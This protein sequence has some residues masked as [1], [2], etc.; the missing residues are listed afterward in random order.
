M[1]DLGEGTGPNLSHVGSSVG[2]TQ[3]W[4]AEHIR[5]PKTHT[6]MSQMPAYKDIMR[7][8]D[9]ESLASHL[10]AQK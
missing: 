1:G 6:P 2:R 4:I 5:N 9:I 10:A 3:A 7:P 8:Q